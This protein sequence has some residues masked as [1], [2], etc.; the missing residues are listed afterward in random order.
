MSLVLFVVVVVVVNANGVIVDVGGGYGI[1][2]G[3]VAA[4]LV[5]A[6]FLSQWWRRME[7]VKGGGIPRSHL[8]TKR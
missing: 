7:G 5:L 2:W 1:F 6:G 8:I 4:V 3:I